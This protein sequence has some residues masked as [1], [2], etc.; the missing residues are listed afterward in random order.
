MKWTEEAWNFSADYYNRILAHPFI[1]EL[2]G[3]TLSTEA[4]NRYIGQDEQYLKN[5]CRH[6][7]L[8]ADMISDGEMKEMFYDFA[9]SGMEMEHEMHQMLISRFGTN[10]EVEPSIV[11]RAYNAHT[12]SAIASGKTGLA[13]AA[14]LP[15]M[16]VY[17]EVGLHIYNNQNRDSNPYSEWIAAYSSEE[18]TEG[19]NKVLDMVDTIASELTIEDRDE[20]K[21]AFRTAVAYELYFWDYGY[22]GETKYA[23]TDGKIEFNW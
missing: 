22:Y 5:Y 23:D 16:W 9:K 3:G 14:I 18:F 12:E 17:N 8:L 4:F 19:V 13:L 21:N 1:S 11:T 15:C 6:M 2:A 10:V 7:F 20:M